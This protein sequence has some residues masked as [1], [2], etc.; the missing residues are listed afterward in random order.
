MQD[1]S[2]IIDDMPI[3]FNIYDYAIFTLIT[4]IFILLLFYLF[5]RFKNRLSKKI[6]IDFND[7][8]FAYKATFYLQDIKNSE[9]KK[10]LKELEKYKYTKSPPALPDYLKKR[11]LRLL[12]V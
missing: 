1:I 5:I 4:T 10:L 7:K 8:N 9:A 3:P 12:N 2:D 11:I 6:E